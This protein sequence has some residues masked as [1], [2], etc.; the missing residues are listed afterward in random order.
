M[1]IL[2]RHLNLIKILHFTFIL[3]KQKS[4]LLKNLHF[5]TANYSYSLWG[6]ILHPVMLRK[7][8]H[9]R[10]EAVNFDCELL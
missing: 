7:S 6:L 1:T 5:N 4:Q 9:L 3:G 2:L 8:D 10:V